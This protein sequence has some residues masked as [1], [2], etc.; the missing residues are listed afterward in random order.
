MSVAC[1]EADVGWGFGISST[2]QGGFYKTCFQFSS[3]LCMQHRVAPVAATFS[4]VA[5]RAFHRRVCFWWFS[6]RDDNYK[7]WGIQ[8]TPHMS[9]SLMINREGVRGARDR[10][11]FIGRDAL[12][13]N[14][15]PVPL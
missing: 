2:N 1:F 9:F 6:I 4:E 7:T 13:A 10:K 12:A 5:P 14:T 8:T 15:T 11:D 3:R